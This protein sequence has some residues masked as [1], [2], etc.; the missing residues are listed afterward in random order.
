VLL[1]QAVP[2]VVVRMWP[3][4]LVDQANVEEGSRDPNGFYLFGISPLQ[5]GATSIK[6][7]ES[8]LLSCLRSFEHDLRGNERYYDGSETFIS[9]T[10]VKRTQ[11][12]D[13][14]I[15]DP[16]TWPDAGID[17]PESDEDEVDENLIDDAEET[18]TANSDSWDG[19]H[20]ASSAQRKRATA[21]KAKK[22]THIRAGKLRTSTD[23]YNRLIW[24][25]TGPVT[26]DGYVIGYEDRF[27]GIKEVPLTAWKR[28]VEDESFVSEGSLASCLSL[29]FRR[30]HSTELYTSS[31]LLMMS[32][33]GIDVQKLTWSLGVVLGR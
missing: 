6:H 15:L 7:M 10:Y 1:H 5:P 28:E 11:L 26:K 19:F 12:P 21:A 25:T 33:S 9:L 17:A 16:F 2:E 13:T 4:R 3:Q 31:V 27:K 24:D 8:S 14:V 18:P 20:V 23:V 22:T 29:T 32:M 30:Y